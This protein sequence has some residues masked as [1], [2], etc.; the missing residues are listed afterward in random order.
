MLGCRGSSCWPLTES[1]PIP[2][3]WKCKGMIDGMDIIY[4]GLYGIIYECSIMDWNELIIFI[5]IRVTYCY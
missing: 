2:V 5:I 3:P 1:Y 4:V